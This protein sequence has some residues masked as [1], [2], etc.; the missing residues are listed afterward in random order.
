MTNSAGLDLIP[1][2][3][4]GVLRYKL[5]TVKGPPIITIV[6]N[7]FVF[8]ISIGLWFRLRWRWLFA[9]TAI[10]LIGNAIPSVLVGTLP[11]SASEFVLALCLLLTE[12][13]TRTE[14]RTSGDRSVGAGSPLPGI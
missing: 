9:G 12:R 11:G 1:V 3:F 14:R 8:A 13:R 4:A 5:A 2:T 6:V 10:A 7:L